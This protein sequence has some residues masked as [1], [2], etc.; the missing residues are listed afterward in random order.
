MTQQTINIGNAA[1]DRSGDPLRTAFTKINSNFTD[2]YTQ[3]SGLELDAVIPSQTGNNGKYLTTNGTTLSWT[4]VSGVNGTLLPSDATGYLQNDGSGNLSWHTPYIPSLGN[5]TFNGSTLSVPQYDLTIQA[6]N[7]QVVLNGSDGKLHIPGY[8]IL[9]NGE[10]RVA[11]DGGPTIDAA[12]PG[13]GVTIS[14]NGTASKWYFGPDGSL[15]VPNNLNAPVAGGANDKIRL[16]NFSDNS[17]VNYAI[18]TEANYVWNSVDSAETGVGFKWY[19][20]TTEIFKIEGDGTLT[21]KD[22]STIS[23]GGITPIANS[24]TFIRTSTDGVNFNVWNFGANNRLT[25]PN[26]SIIQSLSGVVIANS[27][28]SHGATAGITIPVNGSGDMLLANSYG[29]VQITS[30]GNT[31]ALGNDGSLTLPN[32]GQIINFSGTTIIVNTTGGTI[33]GS[34]EYKATIAARTTGNIDLIANDGT[35][36]DASGRKW[37]FNTTGDIVFPDGTVQ[38]SAYQGDSLNI[39]G[40]GAGTIFDIEIEFVDGGTG[41]ETT[42]TD[43]FSGPGANYSYSNAD[44]II[45][46][47][48]V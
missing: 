35:N 11:D 15:T 20:G 36:N 13:M 46:G 12:S 23:G 48:G 18:G 7:K 41:S 26:N 8:L 9:P 4:T 32:G 1:N 44:T 28:N 5:F 22:G 43:T 19:G 10:I 33:I 40:G 21:F 37:T 34:G 39:D 42:W 14:S 29:N 16:Y 27:D 2:L 24:D 47:G 17:K 38:R 6:G 31:W 25:L 45:N 30:S 3:I